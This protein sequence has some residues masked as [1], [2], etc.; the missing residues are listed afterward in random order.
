[1][2]ARNVAGI[3]RLLK[4]PDGV[5]RLTQQGV[6]PAQNTPASFGHHI[7]AEVARFGKSVKESGAR[8]G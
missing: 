6:D 8:V 5:K 1:M 7:K 4:Q 2:T 3:H